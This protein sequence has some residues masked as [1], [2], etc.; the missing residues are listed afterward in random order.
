MHVDFTFD[1]WQVW[2]NIYVCGFLKLASLSTL[3]FG[4]FFLK[5]KKKNG[6][7]LKI[8]MTVENICIWIY[9][10]WKY[11]CWQDVNL[12]MLKIWPLIRCK[13]SIENVN[14]VIVVK[15]ENKKWLLERNDKER[16]KNNILIKWYWKC[17]HRNSCW[18]WNK[19]TVGKKW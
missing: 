3:I 2:W 19:M 10:C 14:V 4:K 7:L 12:Y 18:I 6:R 16:L 17:D 5:K 15:F 11:D 1:I 13:G 9:M 8:Y